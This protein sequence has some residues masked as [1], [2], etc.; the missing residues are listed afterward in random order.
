MS[1]D[2]AHGNSPTHPV[3]FVIKVVPKLNHKQDGGSISIFAGFCSGC[4]YCPLPY[5][6]SNSAWQNVQK[7]FLFLHPPPL[8]ERYHDALRSVVCVTTNGSKAGSPSDAGSPDTCSL[9][10]HS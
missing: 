7:K 3:S 8:L 2:G 1:S 9:F 6:K 4:I 5:R 10:P